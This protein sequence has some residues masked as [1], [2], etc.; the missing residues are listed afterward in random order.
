[1]RTH[2]DNWKN[3]CGYSCGASLVLQYVLF[4]FVQFVFSAFG[5]VFD[6]PYLPIPELIG[7]IGGMLGLG[8]LHTISNFKPLS[9]DPLESRLDSRDEGEQG[10]E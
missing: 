9:S 3:L 5:I 4:P 6:I 8:T 2:G 1:M 10:Q 7:I